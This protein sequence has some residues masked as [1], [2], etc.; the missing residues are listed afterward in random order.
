MLIY[1]LIV[2]FLY[3]LLLWSLLYRIF[4]QGLNDRNYDR[5]ERL[6]F[7]LVEVLGNL[8]GVEGV[9]CGFRWEGFVS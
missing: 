4:R 9:R 5:G 3:S 6:H 8:F 2:Y 7:Y 1:E